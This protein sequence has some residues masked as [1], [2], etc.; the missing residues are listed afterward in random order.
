MTAVLAHRPFGHGSRRPARVG[1]ALSHR[2]AAALWRIRPYSG[3]TV[4]VMLRESEYL[5]LYDRLSLWDLLDRHPHRRGSRKVRACLERREETPDGRV[6]S[7]LEERF[8]PFLDRHGLPRPRFNARV[9]AGGRWHEVDCLWPGPREIVE[10]DGWEGHGTRAAFREDRARDRRLR[11]AG[12]G[13][14]RLTWNQLEDE[15]EFVAR[16]LRGLLA[17]EKAPGRRRNRI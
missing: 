2:C 1:A 5:R 17:A 3:A 7:P 12:Y 11:A 9:E 15:P 16:D 6:R 4:E 14:T 8:L 13:V 10:L